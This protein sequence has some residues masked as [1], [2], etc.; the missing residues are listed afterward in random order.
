MDKKKN[1]LKK[2]L[3][4]IFQT[5][6]NEDEFHY[7]YEAM[8]RNGWDL[9]KLKKAHTERNHINIFWHV[10]KKYNKNLITK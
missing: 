2:Q 6:F 10:N 8:V 7:I 3:E 4:G 9:N 5:I 1:L